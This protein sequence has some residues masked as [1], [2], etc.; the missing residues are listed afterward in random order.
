MAHND[1]LVLFGGS[2]CLQVGNLDLRPV[3]IR[4]EECI[5]NTDLSTWLVKGAHFFTILATPHATLLYDHTTDCLHYAGPDAQVK[6]GFPVNHAILCQT[7]VDEGHIPRLLVMD[8]VQPSIP[9]PFKRNQILRGLENTLPAS[10]HLQWAGKLESL[11]DFLSSVQ[12]PHEVECEIGI[13]EPLVLIRKG[14]GTVLIDSDI[15]RLS[16]VKRQAR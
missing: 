10:C 14:S 1:A 4:E 13:R 6:T 9:C 8:L 2:L 7:V 12:L 3:T 5:Q 15:I 11:R 16:G